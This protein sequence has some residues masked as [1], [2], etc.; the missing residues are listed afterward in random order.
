MGSKKAGLKLFDL[1]SLSA[2]QVIGAGVVTIIG[3]AVAVT[4]MSAWPAYGIAVIVGFIS[5]IPFILL[6]SAVVLKGGDYSIVNSMIKNKNVVGFFSIAFIVQCL[7]LSMM[8]LS[9]ANYVVS[10]FPALN[11]RLLALGAVTFFFIMNLMG[12]N[13]MAK[14]Q[15]VLTVILIVTLL[16]FCFLGIGKVSPATF[17]FAAPDFFTNGFGGFASAVSLYA[18][19]TYGQYMVINYSKNAENPKRDIPLAIIISSGIILVI[20][21]FIAIVACGILPLEEVAHQPLTLVARVIF[22]NRF[23]PVFVLGGPL[24]ALA[25]TLNS[26]FSARTNVLARATQDGWFPQSLAK[27]NKNGVHYIIM[28]LIYLTGIL[29]IVFN[30]SIKT[31]TNNLV[32]VSYILRMITAMAVIK[33][34]DIYKEEWEASP[35][36]ISRPAFYLLMVFVFLAQFYMIWISLCDLPFTI[37]AIN[38]AFMVFCAFYGALRYRSGKVVS[39][40]E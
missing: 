25:T 28:T 6:S 15:K 1:V 24:M 23:L 8:G 19:S 26:T 4:G 16:A 34:P 12:V 13:M 3:E 33:M 9:L 18:Y 17:D 5:I 40:A 20:Y 30:L 14:I 10:L 22:G 38:V 32:L 31:I 21:V 29:P 11:K 39:N 36:Y 27:V 37:A 7:S 35:Y 2:G